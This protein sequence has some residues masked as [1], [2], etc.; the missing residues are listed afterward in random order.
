MSVY[1]DV[2]S[3]GCPLFIYLQSLFTSQT[4]LPLAENKGDF[5]KIMTL[6]PT[7][8]TIKKLFLKILYVTILTK[9]VSKSTFHHLPGNNQLTHALTFVLVC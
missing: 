7:K 4:F 3:I 1:S 6:C 2:I 9:F 5:I 8:L